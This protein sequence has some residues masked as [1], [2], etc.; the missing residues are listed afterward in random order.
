MAIEPTVQDPW[1]AR[2]QLRTKE[3]SS[4]ESEEGKLPIA[5]SG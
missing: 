2:A 5:G 3:S 1:L 4:C